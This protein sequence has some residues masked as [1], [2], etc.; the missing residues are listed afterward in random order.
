[1]RAR[2]LPGRPLATGREALGRLFSD[3]AGW[4]T[5]GRKPVSARKG[6]CK[7]GCLMDYTVI[8]GAVD[9]TG[10]AVGIGA[11]AA[12]LAVILTSKRGANILLSF[13]GR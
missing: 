9:F 13:I 4:P 7:G 10:V 6:V 5:G 2:P 1:M 12:L 11:I 3:L 8:S